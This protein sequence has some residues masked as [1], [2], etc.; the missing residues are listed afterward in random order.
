M[1]FDVGTRG[2]AAGGEGAAQNQTRTKQN[3][4][5]VGYGLQMRGHSRGRVSVSTVH[6]HSSAQLQDR[7]RVLGQWDAGSFGE[8]HLTGVPEAAGP[9][10]TVGR[11]AVGN[12][13]HYPQIGVLGASQHECQ[14]TL[15]GSHTEETGSKA[16]PRTLPLCLTSGL[17]VLS[18]AHGRLPVRRLAASSALS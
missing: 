6:M 8:L 4:T 2:G 18:P 5:S 17:A 3:E 11:G 7:R 13:F 14:R 15:S 9:L 1:R 10:K 12:K 16:G